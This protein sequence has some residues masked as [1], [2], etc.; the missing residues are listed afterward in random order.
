MLTYKTKN[1]FINVPLHLI[2][3]GTLEMGPLQVTIQFI[4]YGTEFSECF[5]FSQCLSLINVLIQALL[6]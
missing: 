2:E 3:L 6:I 1:F 4:R 5:Q